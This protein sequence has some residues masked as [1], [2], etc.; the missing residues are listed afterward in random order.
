LPGYYQY[1]AGIPDGDHCREGAW[2]EEKIYWK[3]IEAIVIDWAIVQVGH[4]ITNSCIEINFTFS[5]FTL[6]LT[7]QFGKDIY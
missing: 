3:N 2:A 7:P 6:F 5:L 4:I 1:R